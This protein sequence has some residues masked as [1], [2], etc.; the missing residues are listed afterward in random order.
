MH[1]IKPIFTTGL[2]AVCT[3]ST[4][5]DMITMT[6]EGTGSGRIGNLTFDNSNFRI[7]AISDTDDR[8]IL[9]NAFILEHTSASINIDGV[10]NFDFTVITHTFA[11]NVN[12]T[13]GFSGP[14]VADLF[15]G[16]INSDFGFWDM[17]TSIGPLEGTGQLFQWATVDIQ[18]TGG[19]LFFNTE[20]T[21]ATFTATVVPTQAALSL[22]SISGI[23]ATRRRRS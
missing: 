19:L 3:L 11:N 5:A 15:N 18:T 23:A 20:S 2:I 6:H 16:P 4:Q 22:L 13:I 8:E 12:G 9:G 21:D 1:A 7:T 10:G 17:T 14:T